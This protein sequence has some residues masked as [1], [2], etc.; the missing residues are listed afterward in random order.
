MMTM[1]LMPM[2]GITALMTVFTWTMRQT[3]TMTTTM[4][5]GFW[6]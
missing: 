2:I 3:T 6:L 1:L 4:M 5:T